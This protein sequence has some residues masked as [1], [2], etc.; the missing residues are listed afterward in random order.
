MLSCSCCACLTHGH[1]TF[2]CWLPRGSP[3]RS[4]SEWS[5]PKLYSGA[6]ASPISDCAERRCTGLLSFSNDGKHACGKPVGLCF[7]AGRT[8]GL[9]LCDLRI[10]EPNA[11]LFRKGDP[12]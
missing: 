10:A 1:I 3:S 7:D 9:S 12:R 8:D 2:M 6:A 4:L 5:S 11:P